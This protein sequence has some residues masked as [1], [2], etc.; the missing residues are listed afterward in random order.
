MFQETAYFKKFLRQDRVLSVP[1]QKQQ[2]PRSG[3]NNG[4]SLDGYWSKLETG[5]TRRQR[6]VGATAALT[7]REA[8]TDSQEVTG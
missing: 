3:S 2:C 7:I 5:R 4:F 8:T 6:A 1:N